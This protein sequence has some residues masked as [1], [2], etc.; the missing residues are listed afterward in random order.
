MEN[1]TKRKLR[2]NKKSKVKR[3]KQNSHGNFS[4]DIIKKIKMT[5]KNKLFIGILIFGLIVN[6]LVIFDLNY[7]YIRA[8][9]TFVFLITIPGLLI[10]LCL[11]IRNINFWE[12]LVYTIGLSVAFIMFAGLAVNWILPFLNIT[13]KPLS[14]YP[15]LICFDTILLVLWLIAH[16]RNEDH[17]HVL[18]FPFEEYKNRRGR[19]LFKFIPK[20]PSLSWLDRIFMIIPIFFPFMAVIGAFLLNNHGTNIVTMIML[21]AIAV[22]VFFVVFFRDKLNE[23]VYPWA[24]WMIGLGLLLSGTLRSYYS[25][26]V[27]INL[28]F[29]LSQLTKENAIWTINNFKN[30]YN[31]ML[32]ITTMPTIISWFSNINNNYI[33][34]LIYP[35]LFSFLPISIYML[36]KKYINKLISFLASFFFI[37]QP[38]ILS[39]SSIPYRQQIA[40]LFFGLMLLVLFTKE[41]NPKIKNLLF[42]IFG[43]S[44]IVSHYSTAYIALFIFLLTYIL[45]F[46]Y[47]LYENKKINKER[48][49]PE[50]RQEFHLTGI[51]ILLLLIFGFLWY[52][53]VTPTANGLV[54]FA[55]KS[56]SN[57][58][59]LF[60]E[61]VQAEGQSIVNQFNIFYNP[62]D[63]SLK[64]N[65][66]SSS[67]EINYKETYP[68]LKFYPSSDYED[69]RPKLEGAEN[70]NTGFGWRTIIIFYNI[71]EILKWL[72]KLFLV[73]GFFYSLILFRNNKNLDLLFIIFSSFC[74]LGLT[75]FL[76]FISIDYEL[77][78]VYQQTL[79]LLSLTTG[80]GCW[81]LFNFLGDHKKV[82]IIGLFFILYFLFLSRFTNQIIGGPDISK[83]FNNLGLE[84]DAY[85]THKSEFMSG[86]WFFNNYQKDILV[87]LDSHASNKI[88]STKILLSNKIVKNVLPSIIDKNSYV[89]SSE[90]NKI[91]ELTFK[92]YEGDL[93]SFN[94]PTEFLND[95]KN[96]I[97]NNG[98]SEI[99]K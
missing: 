32:S 36:S 3:D 44:M 73:I 1:N 24:L 69:Y 66:F 82:I 93:M 79:I 63:L 98:G 83:N 58:G 81:K 57:F 87:Y 14:L 17:A 4:L 27:D 59:N 12:Y 96:K 33:F 54:D 77:V 45:I 71:R 84:Y 47:K 62:Q 49:K 86:K 15:I 99:F 8:I 53:Q 68:E 39:G 13:D 21:G 95:N 85:Y 67:I 61:D 88:L 72:G 91:R 34:K 37:S 41:I 78:R 65:E 7:F 22:Y 9:L 64:L 42:V 76:P 75:L 90:T 28:E 30:N 80:L 6:L 10:M 55:H 70:L 40:F 26:G 97:Y 92:S 16:K 35:I 56:F 11:K 18:I 52:S 5:P 43:F 89:Y 20:F 46:F 19:G 25:S 74:I 31:A 29:L 23:N 51:L 94:F 48:L 38:M 2:N 60:S 50:Q